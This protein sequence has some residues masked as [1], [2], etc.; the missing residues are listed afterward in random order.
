MTVARGLA[1]GA[2]VLAGVLVAVL[3][4]GGSDKTEYRLLFQNAGQ[5]V[6]DD[7]VQVGGR[8]VGSIRDIKLTDDNQAEIKV[9][10]DEEFSPLREGT[11]AT[12]RATSLSGIANRYIALTPGPNNAPELKENSVLTSD[13]TTPI[14]DLDQLFNTLDPEAR[15]SLQKVIQGSAEQYG[16][17]GEQANEAAKY[18]NPAISTTRELVNEL[19]FDSKTLQQFLIDGAKATGAL[20]ERRETLTDLVSN[21]NAS[22][23]GIARENA[24]FS[25]TLQ[26]L[27][28][29]LRRA[30]STFVNLRGTLNDLDVLVAESKPA[31]KDL[32]RFLRELRPLVRDA[33]PT[34]KDL[35]YAIR[36]S[37]ANNDLIDLMEKAPK[38]ADTAEPS[39]NNTTRAVRK[40]V[41]VVDFIRPYMPD[42]TGWLREFGQASAVYDANGHIARIQPI[43]NTF[44][45]TDNP[46]GGVLQVQDPDD[47]LAG[48]QSGFFRRCPGGASQPA[49]D[50]SAPWRD[51]GDLDCDARQVLPGP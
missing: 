37:G 10:V 6:K 45:F 29:T 31:T 21:A 23:E 15:R 42:F 34:I 50:N 35:R 2:L 25:Q 20:A 1:L 5:L 43:F 40:S 22:A 11:R 47:R 4:L 27:P 17:K 44:S 16:G 39:L 13:R 30:N 14:V 36:A 26:L 12:I 19:T 41:P 24:A 18:F 9:E 8:R 48:I 7:D 28:N 3:L 46:A 51:D 32:A 49:A 38:L 33:R